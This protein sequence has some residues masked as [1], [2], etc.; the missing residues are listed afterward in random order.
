MEK[1][2]VTSQKLVLRL[3][4]RP[5]PLTP[6]LASQTIPARRST[7]PASRSGWI[8]R[9]AAVGQQPGRGFGQQGGLGVVGLVPL[10]IA[11]G[12]AQPERAAEI[13]DP[14]PGF[15]QRRRKLERNFGRCSQED[16]GQLLR[17]RSFGTGRD[18]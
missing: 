6:D 16:G 13:D 2:S 7:T 1:F 14:G 8:A 9:F 11:L 4:L 10:R 3:G 5:A 18:A 15:K 12:S 17:P